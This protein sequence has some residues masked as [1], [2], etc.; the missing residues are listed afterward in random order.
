MFFTKNSLA[1]EE[2]DCQ[3]KS[4]F[5]FK[6]TKKKQNAFGGKEDTNLPTE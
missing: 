6:K 1:T 2:C 5:F 3:Y 4:S